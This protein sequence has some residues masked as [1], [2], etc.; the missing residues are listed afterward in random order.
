MLIE[1]VK[2]LEDDKVGLCF[3]FVKYDFVLLV[4]VDG[5]FGFVWLNC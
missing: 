1:G 3:R 5:V 4:V 2:E